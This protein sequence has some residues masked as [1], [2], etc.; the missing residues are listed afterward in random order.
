MIGLAGF[1]VFNNFCRTGLVGS[2]S[3]YLV[4]GLG[5]C[6]LLLRAGLVGTFSGH[7]VRG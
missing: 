6:E 5:R 2:L 7:L 1:G 3:G 4:R